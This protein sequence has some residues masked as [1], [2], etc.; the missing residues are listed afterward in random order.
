MD[1]SA[2]LV[3][4]VEEVQAGRSTPEVAFRFHLTM[5]EML[6][7]ACAAQARAG[8][9]DRVALSGGVFQNLLL[10]ELLVP[11]LEKAGF[12]VFTHARVPCNDGGLSLGQA[13]VARALA[14]EA[15]SV[16]LTQK[17]V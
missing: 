2:M 7:D 16:K 10:C 11:R 3:A 15:G 5:A 12:K 9:L 4:L 8:G 6:K 13:A 1:Y 17:Y 14:K